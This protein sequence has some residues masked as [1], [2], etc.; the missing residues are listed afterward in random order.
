MTALRS[1]W[2][3]RTSRRRLSMSRF[4]SAVQVPSRPAADPAAVRR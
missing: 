2:L 3:D 1:K 4:Y